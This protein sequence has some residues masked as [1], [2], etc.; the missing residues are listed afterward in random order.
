MRQTGPAKP[1][2]V[3]R[4][5]WLGTLRHEVPRCAEDVRRPHTKSGAEHEVRPSEV[6]MRFAG[7]LGTLADPEP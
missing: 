6:R 3:N 1:Q 7:G 2:H 4:L 5:V